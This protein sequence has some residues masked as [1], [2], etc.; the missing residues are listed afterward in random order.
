MTPGDAAL[1]IPLWT[2]AAVTVIKALTDVFRNQK[3]DQHA[4]V[5]QKDAEVA[6]K[7]VIAGQATVAG[8]VTEVKTQTNGNTSKLLDSVAALQVENG[9]LQGMIQGLQQARGGARATD[10]SPAPAT[11]VVVPAATPTGG[12]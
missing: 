11:V 1:I 12:V 2:A 4:V 10:A 6:H 3:L 9:R 8:L 7:E 5:A